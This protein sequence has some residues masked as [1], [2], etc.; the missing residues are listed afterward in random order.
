MIREKFAKFMG[1]LSYRLLK[2][3]GHQASTFPG[4]VMHKIAPDILGKLAEGRK[5][6]AVTGTNGKTTTA[7]MTVD[8]L[9]ALGY[10]V[11]S[12][13]SGANLAWGL[14][15]CLVNAGDADVVVLE[16]D[17]AVFAREAA[18]L[19]PHTVLVTNI[20]RDQLDR[21][22][23]I[24]NVR[25]LIGKGID[26]S[27]PERIVLCADDPLVSTLGKAFTPVFFGLD[28]A[29]AANLPHRHATKRDTSDM[30]RP[31][32]PA[33]GMAEGQCPICQ[34]T[35]TYTDKTVAHLGLFRCPECGYARPAVDEEFA[36]DTKSRA[37]TWRDHTITLPLEGLYNAYNAAAALSAS[38]AFADPAKRDVA[39]A[40]ASLEQVEARFG[41]LER[42]ALEDD[43]SLCFILVKNPAGFEQALTIV[44]QADDLGGILFS[45]NDH[46]PDGRDISWIWDVPFEDFPTPEVPIGVSGIRRGDMALRL[47]YWGIDEDAVTLDENAADVTAA[48]VDKMSAGQC[49][50][51]L[52]NY[53][54]MLELREQLAK[55]IG[56]DTSWTKQQ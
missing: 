29:S 48:L 51:L 49:L 23:E 22:G 46:E 7:M 4:K 42:I 24:T 1:R 53:T 11:A 40:M 5:I 13:A 26:T 3:T 38:F 45:L 39:K 8:I 16:V 25:D 32:A 17:E 36:F 2:L 12:N 21:Y 47:A 19:R 54:A 14:S 44:D 52:P 6:L 31:E 41:R 18:A 15:T 9:R 56:F 43:K 50:Y 28:E 27:K 20:F 55:R 30:P 34:T 37:F 35:L 33:G 10:K